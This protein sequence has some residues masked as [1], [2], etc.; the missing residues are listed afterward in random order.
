MLRPGAAKIV[1][2][3]D[4]SDGLA[5]RVGRCRGSTGAEAPL[6]LC[7]KHGVRHGITSNPVVVGSRRQRLLLLVIVVGG[8]NVIV[9]ILVV[10]APLTVG[11]PE[12]GESGSAN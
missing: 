1:A 9:I 11:R 3:D 5:R 8:F 6:L 12:A 2:G 10:S 4:A 7:V